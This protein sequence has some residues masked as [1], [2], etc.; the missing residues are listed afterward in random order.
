MWGS[1]GLK[2]DTRVGAVGGG[3]VGVTYDRDGVDEFK[4][5]RIGSSP[6]GSTEVTARLPI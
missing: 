4:S 3:P 1:R 5:I 6:L 2:W